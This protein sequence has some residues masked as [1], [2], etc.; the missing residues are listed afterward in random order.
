MGLVRAR[1]GTSRRHGFRGG[2]PRSRANILRYEMFV[3]IGMESVRRACPSR[4]LK[5][6]GEKVRERSPE[7][8]NELTPQEEQIARLAR[9]RFP[10]PEIGA[11]LFN[12][13]HTVEWHLRKV[14]ELAPTAS[15]DAVRRSSSHRPSL[16]PASPDVGETRDFDGFDVAR[17]RASLMPLDRGLS[18]RRE[19]W[20]RARLRSTR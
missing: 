19:R 17:G 9:D 18:E 16:A 11:Q 10:T 5:A 20:R 3:A 6:T 1:A 4:E 14:F 2:R 12:S 13:A 15:D 8:S 7:T